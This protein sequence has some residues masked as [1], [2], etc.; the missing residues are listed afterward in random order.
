MFAPLKYLIA[1]PAIFLLLY[2]TMPVVVSA[3]YGG[4][5]PSHL[6]S[7]LD[8]QM[9]TFSAVAKMIFGPITP[10]VTSPANFKTAQQRESVQN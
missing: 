8:K 7:L 5:P 9:E 6:A 4:N 3:M 1:F 10:V 2:G